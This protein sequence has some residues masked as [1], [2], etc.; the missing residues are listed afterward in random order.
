MGIISDV[1]HEGTFTLT[2]NRPDKKNAM[3]L[4]LLQGL[5]CSLQAAEEKKAS[6]VVIRGAGNT[7]CSGGDVIEFRDSDSPGL[8]VDAMADYLNKAIMKIRTIPAAVVAVVE[9]LA[10]GAGLSLTLACD[11]T[12]AEENAIMNLGY[13]RIGLT[14]DGGASFFLPRLIGMKRF[15]D[16]YFRSRNMTMSEA[17]EMGL[18]NVIAA[19]SDLERALGGLLD[20]LRALPFETTARAKELVNLS[21]WQGL[22]SHLD[23]ERLF[24]SRFA[25]EGV[26]QERL[27]QLY[28][29]K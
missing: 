22:G 14:P 13:R 19:K 2:L 10:V 8:K 24:V 23:K 3:S 16:L 6:V 11:L 7:F 29:K 17:R 12:V 18:V 20:E 21:V 15:N 5:Y 1:F 25:E 9:G 28:K 4:E 27:R 26:F